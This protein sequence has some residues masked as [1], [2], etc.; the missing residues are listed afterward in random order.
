MDSPVK[1]RI[2]RQDEDAWSELGSIL[3]GLSRIALAIVFLA[4][5]LAGL[6]AFGVFLAR[7]NLHPVY[8]IAGS[9]LLGVCVWYVFHALRWLIM[10]YGAVYTVGLAG[11]VFLQLRDASD[12]V[13]ASAGAVSFALCGIALSW[14]V[15]KRHT[16]ARGWAF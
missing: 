3:M 15:Y 5:L 12:P 14:S 9:A 16:L 8:C 13:W 1:V 2:H 4:P 6:L 7:E 11:L 10:A